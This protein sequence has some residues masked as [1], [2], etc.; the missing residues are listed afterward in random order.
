M[1]GVDRSVCG[2]WAEMPAGSPPG[3]VLFRQSDFGYQ[4]TARSAEV[5]V[6]DRVRLDPCVVADQT[7]VTQASEID[8]I[9]TI[10][11]GSSG[12]PA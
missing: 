10:T 4:P 5:K 6:K 8:D 12:L 7:Y 3:L 11:E 9:V 2:F 1:A